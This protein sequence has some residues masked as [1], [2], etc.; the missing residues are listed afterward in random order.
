MKTDRYD[1]IVVGAGL[2]G[3]TAAR[4]LGR[5]G[6]SVMVLEGR[7][8]LGGRLWTHGFAGRE[9][10][11]GGAFVHWWQP[12]VFAEMTR[13]GIGFQPGPRLDHWSWWGDGSLHRESELEVSQRLSDLLDRCF[14]D[15]GDTFPLPMDTFSGGERLVARDQESVRDRIDQVG[16]SQADDDLLTALLTAC[17]SAPTDQIS[18]ATMLHWYALGGGTYN[19]LIDCVGIHMVQ[20]TRKLIDAIAGEVRGSIQLEMPV[21]SVAQSD[22]GIE[23]ETREGESFWGEAAIVAVPVTVLPGIKFTPEPPE[24]I[25]ALAGQRYAGIGSKVWIH[26]RGS[27]DTFHVAAPDREPLNLID[28]VYQSGG[29]QILVAFGNDAASASPTDS[30]AVIE[31]MRRLAPGDYE[32]LEVSGHDWTAD[33]FSGGTWAMTAPGQRSKALRRFLEP[34][35]RVMYAGSDVALGWNGFMDGAIESG[36]RAAKTVDSLMRQGMAGVAL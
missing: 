32:V 20:T 31:V 15:V 14:P 16:L 25:Q 4:E 13:H 35:G 34:H 2:A 36:V 29:S 19:G 1:A 33:E 7:A 28:T 26:V 30:Q 22:S 27:E 17:G 10:E 6:H 9:V 12:H 5:L 21:A 3:L 11:Y 24:E 23:I 8:R 18:L